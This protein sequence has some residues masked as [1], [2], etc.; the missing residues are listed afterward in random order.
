MNAA[1]NPHAQDTVPLE[2]IQEKDHSE[3]VPVYEA[4]SK[5]ETFLQQ[6]KVDNDGYKIKLSEKEMS[7]E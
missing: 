5:E 6:D 4:E 7:S 2:K 1:V 3:Q